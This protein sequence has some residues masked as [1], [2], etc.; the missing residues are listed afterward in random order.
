MNFRKLNAILI[1]VT[2]LTLSACG[3][4]SSSSNSA[5]A[6]VQP[7]QPAVDRYALVDTVPA[8][9]YAAN[10]GQ[11]QVLTTINNVRARIG[12]GLVM[13][14]PKLDKSAIAHWQYLETNGISAAHSES[15]S[16]S[17]FTG[18]TATK[19]AAAAGYT[20]VYVDEVISAQNGESKF[21]TCT[22]NW[23]NSVYHINVIFSGV[24]EIGIAAMNTKADPVFGT[25]TVCVVD[26][27][28]ERG[29]MEQLPA[30]GVV[31][32]YPYDTQT[33][34]PFVFYNQTESPTPLPAYP[35]LGA[36]IVVNF[37]TK[38][39]ANSLGQVAVAQFT[40]TAA[41]G[42]PVDAKILVNQNSVDSG[43]ITTNGP[44]L[45]GDA[46]MSPFNIELVPVA[47]LKPSTTYTANVS[48]VVNGKTI[49]KTWA[50]TTAAN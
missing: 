33:N 9:D 39:M 19:R 43:A 4:G 41:G 40:L 49:A 44:A 48:L 35:E 37:K 38:A 18:E 14:S 26:F 47:R 16:V 42:S 22:D 6:P 5:V 23:L 12:S 31:R 24:R 34:V 7:T 3:G 32:V 27:A 30:D 1:A 17:G 21:H 28:F 2:V 50:F 11:A 10:S 45:T 15:P 20:S 46:V 25:Y 8:A 36:P 13:Q 29:E